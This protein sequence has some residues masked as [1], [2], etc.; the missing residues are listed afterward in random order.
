MNRQENVRPKSKILR[1]DRGIESSHSNLHEGSLC[2]EQTIPQL[3]L[4]F[5]L[6]RLP[7]SLE[8]LSLVAQFRV[9]VH[10]VGYPPSV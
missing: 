8:P 9:A 2:R 1:R 4:E 7:T 3:P 6:T 10:E 5:P